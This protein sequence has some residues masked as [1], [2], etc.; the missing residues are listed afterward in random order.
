MGGSPARCALDPNAVF[1][2]LEAVRLKITQVQCSRRRSFADGA[3]AQRGLTLHRSCQA[4]VWL[5]AGRAG[6]RSGSERR[7]A[8]WQVHATSPS[9]R[10]AARLRRRA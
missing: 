9:K 5:P 4:G 10:R 2:V 6:W 3:G 7:H 1:D 8:A